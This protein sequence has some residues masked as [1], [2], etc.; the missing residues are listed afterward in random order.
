MADIGGAVH[1]HHALRRQIEIER[2]EHRLLDLARIGRVADQDDLA[3]EVD[4]DDGVRAHAVALGIGLEA[5]QVHDGKFGDEVLE[6]RCDRPDQKLTN[7][8]RMP[9]KLG[10]HACLDPVVRI[11]TAIEVL[12]V[13]RLA[14]RMLDEVVVEELELLRCDLPVALPPHRLFGERIADGM[15]VLGRTASMHTGLRADRTALHDGGFARRDRMLV[16]LGRVE[17]PMNRSN[18]FEAELVGAVGAVSHT[19]LFHANP[20]LKAP[21]RRRHPSSGRRVSARLGLNTLTIAP[22]R[23][24]REL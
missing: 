3:G 2:R 13:E 1:R 18:I 7:E 10:E 16:E 14:A 17:I 21:G 15:L 20:P 8:Q 22:V 19:R 24:G 4:G 6:L 5:R 11:G 9:G 23:D 12:G